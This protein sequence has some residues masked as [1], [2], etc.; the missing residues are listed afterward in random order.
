MNVASILK[1]KGRAVTTVR[2]NATLLD[3]AKKLGPKKIGA[4][5]VVG[6]N[7]HVAG[8][9]SERDI[10]RVVSE[11]G[12]AALSMVVSE[13]MTRNVIACGETSELDELMEMMTKGRFRHLPVIED[14]A[15][16]GII[17][18]GDVVRH[19]VAEVEMEVSAM[20]NY[21]ATG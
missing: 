19:H 20:R 3:V 4:V 18:I 13:V 16:V 9:I 5:V 7:G 14:D 1:A 2:P 17:S 8:I 15:L 10:I 6:D 11:H 21:L 12:A